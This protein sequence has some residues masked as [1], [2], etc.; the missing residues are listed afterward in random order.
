ML[1]AA[2]YDRRKMLS[3]LFR[4]SQTAATI[5]NFRPSIPFHKS[6]DK[7]AFPSLEGFGNDDTL[8]IRTIY[9][10]KNHDRRA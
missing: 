2:V 7:R 4:R 5:S 6:L 3:Y 10:N 1:V 9:P 8:A